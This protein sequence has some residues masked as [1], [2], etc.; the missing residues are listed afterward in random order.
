MPRRLSPGEVA[1]IIA[2]LI[3]VSLM[4]L[5]GTPPLTVVELLIGSGVITA[6]AIGFSPQVDSKPR[7]V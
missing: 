6:H 4:T 5:A 1:V 7:Q 3:L 2:I